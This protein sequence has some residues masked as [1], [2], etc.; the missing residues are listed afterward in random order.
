M[1]KARRDDSGRDG[2]DPDAHQGDEGGEEPSHGGN[3]VYVPVAHRGQ[4]TDGPP[5]GGDD[6]GELFRLHRVLH[7]VHD[8]G[9]KEHDEEADHHGHDELGPGF[10]NDPDNHLQGVK[11]PAQLQ[12]PQ[13]PEEPEEPHHPQEQQ[14][15]GDEGQ[16]KGQDGQQVDQGHEGKEVFQPGML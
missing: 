14:V 2:D 13:E 6:V 1:V 5:E 10:L 4:G 8:D 16:V 11:I 15:R 9:G 7:R 3:G 12:H